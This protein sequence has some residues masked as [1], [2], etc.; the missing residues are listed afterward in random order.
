MD[1][2]EQLRRDLVRIRNERGVSQQ[3]L[4]KSLSVAQSS[5]SRFEIGHSNGTGLLR[6]ALQE[7]VLANSVAPSSSSDE[8]TIG[9]GR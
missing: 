9:E 2:I 3:W 5:I 1:Q 6:R 8:E 4:A 7:F